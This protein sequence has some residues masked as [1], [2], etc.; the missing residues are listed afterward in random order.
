M[1]WKALPPCV[2]ASPP[3]V[4]GLAAGGCGGYA[5][6]LGAFASIESSVVVERSDSLRKEPC[7]KEDCDRWPDGDRGRGGGRRGG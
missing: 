1:V 7:D 6:R 3:A 2:G 4:D 5:V